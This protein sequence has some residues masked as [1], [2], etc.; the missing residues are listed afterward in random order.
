L[1]SGPGKSFEFKVLDGP[2]PSALPELAKSSDPNCRTRLEPDVFFALPSGHVFVLGTE[3]STREAAVETWQPGRTEGTVT[4]LPGAKGDRWSDP[5]HAVGSANDVWL[6]YRANRLAHFDGARFRAEQAPTAQPVSSISVAPDG[7]L[8]LVAKSSDFVR[9]PAVEAP[10]ELWRRTRDGAWTRVALPDPPD[11][12]ERAR[13]ATSVV[14]LGAGDVWITASGRLLRTGAPVAPQRIDWE[15]D[16]QLAGGSFRVPRAATPQCKELFV[17]LYGLTRVAPPDY[18]YPLTRAAL[19][20]RSE[21][22]SARFV[23][24]TENGRRFFG[25][26]VP[27]YAAGKKLVQLVESKVKGSIPQL[28]CHQP[29]VTR[30]FD[31]DLATGELRSVTPAGS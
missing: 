29:E 14:A 17:L 9:K 23:E 28:L 21:F 3:C 25:A 2:P 26:F 16:Q 27:D 30:R 1:P 4:P 12:P 8:W 5:L 11:F 18:D 7:T 13:G 10:G 19:K 22:A 20:G 6:A 31:I 24:T 15:F